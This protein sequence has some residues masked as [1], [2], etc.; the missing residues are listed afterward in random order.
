MPDNRSIEYLVNFSKHCCTLFWV[1]IYQRLQKRVISLPCNSIHGRIYT[2]L[3]Y[4]KA[5][6]QVM[7]LKI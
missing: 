3:N 5:I 2:L 7:R 4:T 1:L 6:L